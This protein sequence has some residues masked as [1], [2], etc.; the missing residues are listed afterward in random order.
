M[1]ILNLNI[2]SITILLFTIIISE[3]PIQSKIF[4]NPGAEWLYTGSIM[5]GHTFYLQWKYEGDTLMNDF[6][7]QKISCKQK[8]IWN[9]A[10]APPILTIELD[11]FL[12]RSTGDSLLISEIDGSN[13]KLLYDFT[14]LIGN[15]WDVTSLINWYTV[16][17]T[18]P[19]IAETIAFGDT[20]I[21]GISVNWIEVENNNPD[22]LLFNG[23]FYNHF[24]H[25]Q[26]FPFWID[27]T[28]DIEPIYWRCYKDD[29]LG[30]INSSQC[31]NFETL[32]I[33]NLNEYEITIIPNYWEQKLEIEC[34]LSALKLVSIT[35]LL[36][37]II[38]ENITISN[39]HIDF[40]QPEGI[41]IIT[42]TSNE[43]TYSQKFYWSNKY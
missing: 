11:P 22:S 7:Y 2:R 19:L 15:S 36:G 43:L 17:P 9:G 26:M 14:P 39:N 8:N 20:I 1:K 27:G 21:N 3:N 33:P 18:S 25:P 34:N 10:G 24:G 13:E 29:V 35:N 40:N 37:S 28:L 4:V 16:E 30:E 31:L 6:T 5:G 42:I 12:F 23:R 32:S 38:N 41:Y